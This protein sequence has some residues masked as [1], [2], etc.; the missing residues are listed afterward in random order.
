MGSSN[1]MTGGIPMGSG[2]SA[3]NPQYLSNPNAGQTYYSDS[4]DPT[5]NSPFTSKDT[6]N[7]QKAAAYAQA[8][9]LKATNLGVSTPNLFKPY[10]QYMPTEYAGSS[11]VQDPAS[12]LQ[13]YA[14]HMP[15]FINGSKSMYQYRTPEQINNPKYIAPFYSN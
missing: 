12:I 8:A 11:P 1:A 15:D 3:Q 7:P 10:A 6:Q 13:A 5:A 4:L 2:G 14:Q 9:K